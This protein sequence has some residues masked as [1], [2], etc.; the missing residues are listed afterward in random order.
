MRSLTSHPPT[1]EE[2]FLRHYGDEL[3]VNEFTGIRS[4]TR[5]ATRRD[6]V[7]VPAW[8]A[9]FVLVVASSASATVGLY[10]TLASRMKAAS[11]VNDIPAIVALYGRIWDPSSLGALSIMK[12][13]GFG[14]AMIAVLAVILVVR[15]T[16]TEEENGRLEM[17]GATVL[18]RRATLTA[19]LLVAFAAMM[20]IG[21]LTAIGQT[22]VGLPASG[23]W[24][25]GLAL[26]T[27]G[28]AFAA[29]AA[30]TAQLTVGARSAIGAALTVLAVSYLLRA[31]GDVAGG[32]DG[33]A[34]WSWLSPIG[35]GQQVR[36][37]AGDRWWV[38]LIP[39]VFT[40]TA[41]GGA[42]ALASR[43]DLGAG[44]LPD[45]AGPADAS[46]WLSSPLAMAWRLQR[47]LLL[48]WAIGYVL[49]ACFLGVVASNVG[50]M[51]DSQ[52]ARDLIAKL[53][54]THVLTDAFMAA[55]L[56]ISAFATA[57]YGISVAMRL[58]SEEAS[59]H[60]EPVLA[61]SV[62]RLRG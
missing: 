34:V 32:P 59:G 8:V 57:A 7:M 3:A 29:V 25:F 43:R 44:L 49:L 54:G 61:G 11:A 4:M 35:W 52:Q 45:R 33:S 15:H 53:G 23:S 10:P 6:R 39:V 27:T 28:M 20:L 51:L 30:V 2:L 24:A 14:A 17:L 9:V 37:Y 13:S 18:G 36:P 46:G 12:L 58:H 31:I 16:R 19:A 1:L 41:I 42:Y 26:T 60:A 22:A 5:L 55:D 40:V 48:G 47:G 62:S 50:D 56:S 21:L 38:L